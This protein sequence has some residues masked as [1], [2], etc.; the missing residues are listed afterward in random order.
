MLSEP[1]FF[2]HASLEGLKPRVLTSTT[3]EDLQRGGAR[4]LVLNVEEDERLKFLKNVAKR[5]GLT[6]HTVVPGAETRETALELLVKARSSAAP[7]SL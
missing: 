1:G 6:V 3:L 5:H 2:A 4:T 7:A